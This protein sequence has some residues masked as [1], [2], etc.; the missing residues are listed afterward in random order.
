MDLKQV[1]VVRRDLDM[2][3][4]KL[5][6]QVAHASVGAIHRANQTK[7]KQWMQQ[8]MKK[9]VLAVD[10][11]EELKALLKKANAAKLP[12]DLISDAG[13]TFL[14]PGT[15]TCLGIGPD[16]EKKIDKVSGK[17]ETL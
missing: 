5:A 17:L 2:P 16:D 9:V 12:A 15:V 4:G 14:A 1:I 6:A 11:E 8:G 13:R 3:K 7:Q 10:S